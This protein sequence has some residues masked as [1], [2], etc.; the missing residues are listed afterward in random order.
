MTHLYGY[1]VF[2]FIFLIISTLIFYSNLDRLRIYKHI[3]KSIKIKD[4]NRQKFIYFLKKHK[5][6]NEFR[7]YFK[8]LPYAQLYFQEGDY[9]NVLWT[10]S[11]Y[12]FTSWNKIYYLYKIENN[13]RE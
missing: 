4:K 12:Y 11:L 10:Y 3:K 6:Y 2:V 13:E 1:M 7:K 5:K 9:E 8:G